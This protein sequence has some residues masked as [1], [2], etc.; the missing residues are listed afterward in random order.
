MPL[1]IRES[2]IIKNVVDQIEVSKTLN[3]DFCNSGRTW[4]LSYAD[5][6]KL[7]TESEYA[8]WLCAWGFRANHF[9]VLVNSL[10]HLNS[11]ETVNTFLKENGI[12]LNSS[13]GEVKGTPEVY[14][15]Q[16]STLADSATVEFTD[17]NYK[18]PACYYEFA[19]RYEVAPGKLYSG[20]V[21]KSADKIFESTN[22]A[23]S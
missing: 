18:I 20:F 11:I 19:K 3:L 7:S 16:S 5:Y 10:T 12:K 22:S 6:Q 4:K 15:E 14:L 21:A 9:T 8:A 17:G 13:G 23:Q 2:Q 1:L